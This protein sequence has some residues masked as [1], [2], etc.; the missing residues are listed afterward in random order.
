MSRLATRILTGTGLALAATALVWLHAQFEQGWVALVVLTL[1]GLLSIW[2]LDRMGAFRGR[3]L[4]LPLHVALAGLVTFELRHLG[5]ASTLAPAAEL[6]LIYA[7]V[8]GAATLALL[9]LLPLRSMR[10]RRPPGWSIALALWLLPPLFA[11][12]VLDRRFGVEGLAV[13]VVLAKVGDNAGYF[14]GRAC[15]RRHPFP[16]VSPG[17]T[18]AGCVASFVAGTAT[19]AVLLPLTLG[20]RTLAQVA[21]GAVLG[22][23]INLAAQA[24]DLS[25]SWVKRKAGVK[26]SSTLAGASGGVLD[27]IDS[28]LVAAPVALLAWSWVY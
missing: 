5:R 25:E 24:G 28:L 21:L 18:V 14:V 6:G 26:D 3:Q 1:L 2:E 4:R 9:V 20:E 15:G 12:I 13:L 22:G 17:K 19:G 23:L 10:A 7:L 8:G 27:V 16:N 11:L